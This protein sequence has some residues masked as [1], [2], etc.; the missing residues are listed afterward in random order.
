VAE[1]WRSNLQL[2]VLGEARVLTSGLVGDHGHGEVDLPRVEV[3][4]GA[5]GVVAGLQQG[6]LGEQQ[7]GGHLDGGELL[8]HLHHRRVVVPLPLLV[9]LQALWRHAEREKEKR[10]GWRHEELCIGFLICVSW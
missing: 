1:R 2:H 9:L 6:Q 7:G 4:R 3:R 10:R 8:Q 5:D